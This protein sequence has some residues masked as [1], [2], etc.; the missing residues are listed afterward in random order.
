MR[1]FFLTVLALCVSLPLLAQTTNQQRGGGTSGGFSISGGSDGIY[2]VDEV[3]LRLAAD[4][5]P[6]EGFIDADT[7]VLGAMDVLSIE[8]RGVV[9][10]TYRGLVV[11]SEG[12]L[13]IPTIGSV[14]IGDMKLA[15]ARPLIRE[16]LGRNFN[17]TDITVTLEKAKPVTVH[18]SGDVTSPGRYLFPANT[19]VDE[20]LIQLLVGYEPSPAGQTGMLMP[21]RRT[22]YVSTRA[23]G[24]LDPQVV[25]GMTDLSMYAF[26]NILITHRDGTQ[27]IAD[28]LSYFNSGTLEKN[29]YLRDGDVVTLKRKSS[30][31]PR[32]S[33]SGAV[34]FP[35]EGDFR[36]DDTVSRLFHA[37]GGY[38]ERAD[39]THF[40]ISRLQSGVVEVIRVN[41]S[42]ATATQVSL[43]PND[44]IIIPSTEKTFSNESAWISG[45]VSV[46]GNYPII[47][48]ETTLR[49][50]LELAGGTAGRAL[51]SGVYIERTREEDFSRNYL[52]AE[53]QLIERSSDQLMEGMDYM[54]LELLL[55][56]R[57]MFVDM[58][59][60][61]GG[62]D[63]LIR[64]GDRIHIPRDEGTILVMG[65]VVRTG[66]VPATQIASAEAYIARAGGFGVAADPSRIFI[67][68]SGGR[69]WVRA[70]QTPIE[71]G[72]IVFVDRVPYDEFVARRTFEQQDR[73]L[74]NSRYQ[75]VIATVSTFASVILAYVAVTR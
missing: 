55:S 15:E 5:L 22:F 19:R 64:D 50:I 42:I 57:F 21:R 59:P 72:D 26:R 35:F 18:L 29:P 2:Y 11:N 43:Q 14:K 71:S 58:R 23:I 73:Q 4:G 68:K 61:N 63:I 40:L 3:G 37:A 56:Q 53:N 47:P 67:I 32:V 69:E 9:P 7:Y 74:K 38:S 48:G 28:I 46:P 39:S 31:T 27:T 34:R 45:E 41:G 62:T 16:L 51:L 30:T 36:S 70:G 44:R 13:V 65:Q 6:L 66:F 10:V 8:I 17:S 49:D 25:G 33:I 54:R 60:D 20:A 52:G 1:V 12:Y 24:T 75:L